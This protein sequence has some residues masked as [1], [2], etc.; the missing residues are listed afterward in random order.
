MYETRCRSSVAS[1]P[2]GSKLGE[3]SA[4]LSLLFEAGEQPIDAPLRREEATFLEPAVLCR[5]ARC[6]YERQVEATGMDH[7]EQVVEAR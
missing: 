7:R 6:Q 2:R 1:R 5:I 3:G 4:T